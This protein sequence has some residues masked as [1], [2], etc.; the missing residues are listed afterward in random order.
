MRSDFLK[1]TYVYACKLSKI[2]SFAIR[3]YKQFKFPLLSKLHKMSQKEIILRRTQ[4]YGKEQHR[5]VE[6]SRKLDFKIKIREIRFF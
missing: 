5:K 4:K 2:G 3:S 6:I 1:C